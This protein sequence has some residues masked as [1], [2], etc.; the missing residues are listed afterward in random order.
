MENDKYVH[1][2]VCGNIMGVFPK[3][4]NDTK[5]WY[6]KCR[7]TARLC[8][9]TGE[10][11][12]FAASR[13]IPYV[14]LWKDNLFGKYYAKDNRDVLFHDKDDD[15]DTLILSDIGYYFWALNEKR[16][17]EVVEKIKPQYPNYT[18]EAIWNKARAYIIDEEMKKY[19]VITYNDAIN[20]NP[21]N[22]NEL[23]IKFAK[24]GYRDIYIKNA[25]QATAS[26]PVNH[27]NIAALTEDNM[28]NPMQALNDDYFTQMP[29]SHDMSLDEFKFDKLVG[30]EVSPKNLDLKPE[31]NGNIQAINY[32]PNQN[33][34]FGYTNDL[35]QWQNYQRMYA[36]QNAMAYSQ[37]MDPNQGRIYVPTPPPAPGFGVVSTPNPFFPTDPIKSQAPQQSRFINIGS[38][39]N[40][41][42]QI[43]KDNP[44]YSKEEDGTE[45]LDLAKMT[46]PQQENKLS[47]DLAEASKELASTLNN[48]NKIISEINDRQNNPIPQQTVVN[49]PQMPMMGFNPLFYQNSTFKNV[50][51]APTES[52]NPDGSYHY[53]DNPKGAKPG[54]EYLIPTRE[55][56]ESGECFYSYLVKGDESFKDPTLKLPKKKKVTGR[57][58]KPFRTCLVINSDKGEEIYGDPEVIENIKNQK[59]REKELEAALDYK[60]AAVKIQNM[61]KETEMFLLIS[62]LKKYNQFAADQLAFMKDDQSVSASDFADMLDQSLQLLEGYQ[63]QDPLAS[64][65]SPGV[66]VANNKLI[67]DKTKQNVQD[68]MKRVVNIQAIRDNKYADMETA[69]KETG[70]SAAEINTIMK[71]KPVDPRSLMQ[72]KVR[73]QEYQGMQIQNDIIEQIHVPE[74]GEELKPEEIS[75][76]EMLIYKL[77]SL[78]NLRIVNTE[79]EYNQV[80]T[81]EDNVM[82]LNPYQNNRKNIYLFW[83]KRMRNVDEE[84]KKLTDQEYDAW[85]DRWWNAPTNAMNGGVY[86]NPYMYSGKSRKELRSMESQRRSMMLKRT[87]EYS[88]Y[89]MEAQNYAVKQQI[90]KV[91][92]D[93]S[94]MQEKNLY[95]FVYGSGFSTLSWRNL[96]E[97]QKAQ[98]NKVRRLFNL[99]LLQQQMMN[100]TYATPSFNATPQQYN[101]LMHSDRY[102]DRRQRFINKIFSKEEMRPTAKRYFYE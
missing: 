94:I 14:R 63:K 44:G 69:M 21:M 11:D 53:E 86:K 29:P 10:V 42:D 75:E 20:S 79:E 101:D 25:V 12:W 5:R 78:Q 59:A 102:N 81:W 56:I 97:K 43:L 36:Q 30:T 89:I 85:F 76:N 46:Q 16:W 31:F 2:I 66:R 9:L 52:R 51:N 38:K 72:G 91:I 28:I 74:K 33:G 32:H 8:S 100:G 61:E 55:E 3:D 41:I 60:D 99:P 80:K 90:G 13:T 54:D 50:Y 62:T 18:D 48:G 83:K 6:R 93:R 23:Q 96:Q 84:N 88:P 87:A 19:S 92:K 4:K 67:I 98:Q 47:N 26:I 17:K 1:R 49:Q 73:A 22:A 64:V 82:S 40:A 70:M 39:E 7:E 45:T 57:K 68:A 35:A 34:M 95:D 37:F 15:E 24:I 65:K 77:Q 71:Y 27:E 58:N